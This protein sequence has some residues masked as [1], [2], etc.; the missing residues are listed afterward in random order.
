MRGIR[1][2]SGSEAE[3]L[4][5]GG[6]SYA[7]GLRWT[8]AAGQL[9]LAGDAEAAA[10]AEGANFVAL[11]RSFNQFGLATIR[12]APTGIRGAF[13]RP[14][15]GAAAI[16]DAAGAATLAAFPLEDGRWIV[17]A[18]DRKGF[19]PDGDAIVAEAAEARARVE[20]LIR[21][22]PT[23]WRRKFVPAEWDIP[24][25]RSVS[26]QDLL[27]RSQALHLVSLWLLTRRR[28][29][30][31]AL[32]SAGVAVCALAG[33]LIR[34][35]TAPDPVGPVPFQAPKPIAAVWTPAGLAIDRC[36]SAFRDAQRYIAV[37][38]WMLSKYSCQGGEGI[39]LSFVRDLAGQIS[40]LRSIVP[41]AQLSDDG[42]TAILALPLAGL[43][44][45]SAAAQ[46]PPRQRYQLIGI[47]LAQRLNGTLMLQ[48]ARRPLP[49]E[50]PAAEA[51]QPWVA[52]TWS[53]QT[54]APA[55]VW[56]AAI[57][58]LGSISLETLTFTPS[59]NLWQLSGTLYASN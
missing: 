12:N 30:Q 23:S 44:R 40:A 48:S 53:Y 6:K 27:V 7:F 10:I 55:I 39:T 4:A 2:D 24:D 58:R 54:Q 28:R 37:P 38:G 3:I 41:A 13:Y 51:S 29:I 16:A 11:H 36:L 33:L 5:V 17:L 22:S 52:F 20:A 42:R 8:S 59:D 19:L 34:G 15:I 57:A 35:L 1:H 26:P 14:L 32:I 56:A 47:D 25:S 21:Q 50:A 9:S 49:G 43:P 18:I 46:F 31:I 45:M